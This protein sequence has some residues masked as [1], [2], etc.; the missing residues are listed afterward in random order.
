MRVQAFL[1]AMAVN[2]KR[3]AAALALFWPRCSLWWPVGP[4]STQ[5]NMPGRRARLMDG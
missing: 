1:T 2:L 5:P 4:I 3:L